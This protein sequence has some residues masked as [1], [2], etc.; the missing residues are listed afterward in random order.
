M[1][2]RKWGIYQTNACKDALNS[3]CNHRKYHT[4][5]EIRLRERHEEGTFDI[6]DVSRVV[7]AARSTRRQYI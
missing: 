3:F 5:P 6:G 4:M 7:Y 2:A 1:L